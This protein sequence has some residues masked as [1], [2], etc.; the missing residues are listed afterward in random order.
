MGLPGHRCPKTRPPLKGLYDLP[1]ISLRGRQA[2]RHPA[3]LPD[4]S[5][6][7]SSRGAP[8]SEMFSVGRQAGGCGWLVSRGGV[9]TLVCATFLYRPTEGSTWIF[10]NILHPQKRGLKSPRHLA[11]T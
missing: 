11:I 9:N 8:D 1:A 5:R 4:P 7:N 6:S 3:H 2:L 10:A